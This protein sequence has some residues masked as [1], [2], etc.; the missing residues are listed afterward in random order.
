MVIVIFLSSYLVALAALTNVYIVANGGTIAGVAKSSTAA[1]YKDGSLSIND[2]LEKEQ[3]FGKL[4]N[5]KSEQF[6]NIDSVDMTMAMR[7]K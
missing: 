3:A 5:I 4:A 1:V 7:I 2:I 6:H